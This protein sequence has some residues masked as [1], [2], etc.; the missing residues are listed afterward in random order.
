MTITTLRVCVVITLAATAVLQLAVLPW[1]SAVMAAEYPEAAGMRWP[2]LLASVLGLGCVEAILVALWRLLDAV[3]SERIFDPASHRW[4]DVV[5]VA[6]GVGTL[7][8][9]A[10]TGYLVWVGL[11]PISVPGSALVC[12]AGGG[13]ALLLVLVMRELLRQATTLRVEMDGVI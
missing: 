8:S 13:A 10:V 12:A 6:L 3:A 4:V 1:L 7:L 5:V 11:G 9:L 2:L